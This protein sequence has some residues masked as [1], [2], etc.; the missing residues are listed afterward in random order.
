M[1]ASRFSRSR[2][3]LSLPFRRHRAA[4]FGAVL[5]AGAA[6]A[7]SSGCASDDHG[8]AA[9]RTAGEEV[10]TIALPLVAQANGHAYRLRNVFI[11]IWGP[12]PTQL[13]DSGA[14]VQTALS[15]TLTTGAYTA[16]LYDGWTL[17][18]DDGTGA[19]WPVMARRLSSPDVAFTIFNG[20]TSTVSYQFE[21]DGVIVTVGS[22]Q[23]RITAGI[24]EIPAVCAPFGTECGDGAWC[25]P[26]TLTAR[27]RACVVAGATPV[28]APCASPTEC[29]ANASC[30]DL[31]AGPVC[32]AL[33]P[34]E[35]IGGPCSDAGSVC[36]AAGPD[37]GVCQPVAAPTSDAPTSP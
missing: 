14:S 33:C 25:P 17:E 27:A 30:F 16:Y 22:G 1:N 5:A 7:L 36:Q 20:T 3:H 10:G 37:Y 28:G 29:V 26:T 24:Q 21:T 4:S 34:P 13:Y 19:F 23:V 32:A 12:Q 35:Q 2:S 15:A 9:G 18:R 8:P 31:G 6:A 11:N